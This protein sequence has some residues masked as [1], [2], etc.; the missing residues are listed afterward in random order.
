MRKVTIPNY[1]IIGTP[2]GMSGSG[3]TI[4]H[5]I[6][7]NCL[8]RK[9]NYSQGN[10]FM[11]KVCER[12]PKEDWIK[13]SQSMP[14][15]SSIVIID[16]KRKE[17]DKIG[18]RRLITTGL[19]YEEFLQTN[20]G[21]QNYEYERNKFHAQDDTGNADQL[22]G[23]P[24]SH[25][26]DLLWYMNEEKIDAVEIPI[27]LSHNNDPLYN[28]PLSREKVPF[29]SA[30]YGDA[31]RSQIN[32]IKEKVQTDLLEY[33]ESFLKFMEEEGGEIPTKEEQL[34]DKLREWLASCT[35]TRKPTATK[36]FE[37]LS[38]YDPQIEVIKK[39]VT[40]RIETRGMTLEWKEFLT[41]HL[42][43][44]ANGFIKER[45]IKPSVLA[46][47]FKLAFPMEDN[48][49]DFLNGYSISAKY[50]LIATSKFKRNA[51]YILDNRN[52]YKSEVLKL[53]R[54]VQGETFDA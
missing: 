16:D 44:C 33:G 15:E 45:N 52:F 40:H 18:N 1:R 46:S 51:D 34:R 12:L 50:P 25:L 49:D 47:H 27:S 30:R 7:T 21:N 5:V 31:I 54:L 8:R 28:D 39:Y 29:L 38:L 35:P 26:L 2:H 11:N 19:I 42:E 41:A 22:G 20:R 32:S 43:E 17:I 24:T 4:G 6:Q 53:R 23:E 36:P 10:N 9:T 14:P 37:S 13:I 3:S 48:S